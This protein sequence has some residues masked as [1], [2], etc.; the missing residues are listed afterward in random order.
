MA[1]PELV[2][3]LYAELDGPDAE[4]A[5]AELT[6]IWQRC[7]AVLGLTL[8]FTRTGLAADPPPFAGLAPAR[9][10]TQQPLAGAK[11]PR[12]HDQAVLRRLEGFANL[13]VVLTS[14][15]T[16]PGWDH[17]A[18]Q[19]AQVC[20]APDP[21]LFGSAH[22]YVGFDAEPTSGG[23]ALRLAEPLAL[24][25]PGRWWWE[26]TLLA[27]EIALWEPGMGG[28]PGR[29]H[30]DLLLI[31]TPAGEPA[32]SA[33]AWSDATPQIPPLGRYLLYAATVRHH[34]R[35]WQDVEERSPARG[36]RPAGPQQTRSDLAFRR[37]ALV[38]LRLNVERAKSNMEGAVRP[39]VA[40][41]PV[42]DDNRVAGW[43]A[44]VVEDEIADVTAA[45]T[46][47][48]RTPTRDP[49]EGARVNH[50]RQVFV[51]HGRDEQVRR[52]VFGFLQALDLRPLDWE[53]LV[54]ATAQTTPF[55]G[56]VLTKAFEVAQAAVVLL[57]PDDGA[58][59]HPRLRGAREETYETRL[60]GQARPNVI[61]EA[62]MAMARF[63]QRTLLVEFGRLRP[64]AD[65]GGR[66]TI[67]FDG[68]PDS[69]NKFVQRLRFAGCDPN[70]TGNGWLDPDR[71]AGLDVYD[72]DF[73]EVSSPA[74]DGAG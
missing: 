41:G 1:D 56:D 16:G 53:E 38:D 24:S 22:I 50:T 13:S 60:T 12:V 5:Y 25:G 10:G 15:S 3:H 23:T 72:R 11:H 43:L 64:F 69:L 4:P 29:R 61:F 26:P 66:N 42:D 8:P 68:T 6:T 28:D 39:A 67:R 35:V 32:M 52:A 36:G 18:R 57:T 17:L 19:W 74:P 59:L 45:D 33:L 27:D 7:R 55:L 40:G 44:T 30:R 63:P 20:D 49:A 54:G 31:G 2:I 71:F 46:R 34:V 48:A 21:L 51:I 70:T 62:G 58:V 14:A 73:T 37:D 9:R 47:L 65:I